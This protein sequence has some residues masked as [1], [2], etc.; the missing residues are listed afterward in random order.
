MMSPQPCPRSKNISGHLR[1]DL[2]AKV[3]HYDDGLTT[4]IGS[5]HS[6]KVAAVRIS[7]D[8]K[9]IVSVGSEGGIFIWEMPPPSHVAAAPVSSGRR[10]ETGARCLEKSAQADALAEDLSRVT[11][12][13]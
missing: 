11:M 9:M 4:S 12:S 13:R 7:P 6:G 2:C 10:P 1:S 8:R 5:G 3:W